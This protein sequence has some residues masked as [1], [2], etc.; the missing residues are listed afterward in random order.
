MPDIFFSYSSHDRE[1]VHAVRD[2]LVTMGFDVFWD[3]TVPVGTDW[4][5]WIRRH[6]Q[7]ARCAMVFWSANSIGSDNVRHEASVAKNHG[8]L[9]PVMIDPLTAEQF[10]MGFYAL[11]CANLCEWSG[12]AADP[13]WNS[14]VADIEAKLPPPPWIRNRLDAM[15][16]DLT[17]ERTRREAVERSGLT[18]R[19][20]IA[21]QIDAQQSVQQERDEALAELE[22]LKS[23]LS[24]AN[25]RCATRDATI[26]D[27]SQKLIAAEA[28]RQQLALEQ[29]EARREVSRLTL[30]IAESKQAPVRAGETNTPSGTSRS[31]PATAAPR[32][33]PICPHCGR[34]GSIESAAANRGLKG[35]AFT[36]GDCG[37][38]WRE[39]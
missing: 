29:T 36:C 33:A 19:K 31:R 20:E 13:R 37:Y 3:Q 27:L 28:Q 15:E 5:N 7:D 1:R 17:F 21:K 12:D 6:L 32:A 26:A 35:R 4:D 38:D 25:Q 23:H 24:A 8:K 39:T 30:A 10:P 2:L 14:L 18:W 16:R 9:V 34:S 11:Q 22:S